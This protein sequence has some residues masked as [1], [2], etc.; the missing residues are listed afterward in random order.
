VVVVSNMRTLCVM[1]VVLTE[2]EFVVYATADEPLLSPLPTPHASPLPPSLPRGVE[3]LARVMCASPSQ[4]GGMFC[5]PADQIPVV[6][7]TGRGTRRAAEEAVTIG[8]LLGSGGYCDV[9]AGTWRGKDVAVKLPRSSTDKQSI[10]ALKREA[11]ALRK[12]SRAA[13]ASPHVPTLAGASLAR[14]SAQLALVMQPSGVEVTRAP[15]AAAPPGSRERCDLAHTAAAGIFGALRVAHAASILHRDVRP[16]N[17]LWHESHALLID[18]GIARSVK[19]TLRALQ[20]A[21]LGWPDAAPDAALLA[22]AGAGAPWLPCAATDCESAVY[23][24][25]AIAFGEPCGEPPWASSS[26]AAAAAAALAAASSVAAHGP[27]AV[28]SAVAA[29][30]AAARLEARNAWFAALPKA[31]P[32]R[33]AR[34]RAQDAQDALGASRPPAPP[35]ALPPGWAALP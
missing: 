12:L 16:T 35:Y 8:D 18:W 26:R 9:F 21:A 29:A 25:A 1:R 2:D 10:T 31:H 32:L 23:T 24:L 7:F 20:P 28:A 3:L 22:S 13:N 5:C 34:A 4:L 14:G 6:P 15:G 33:A 27:N 19:A 30:V 11:A 17:V